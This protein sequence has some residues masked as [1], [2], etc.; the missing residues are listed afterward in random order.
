MRIPSDREM[1]RKARASYIFHI[2]AAELRRGM[3]GPFEWRRRLGF[4]FFR[5]G[6]RV[7]GAQVKFTN[8]VEE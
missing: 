2:D 6:V 8:E 3:F 1:G 7:L 4:W 5:L